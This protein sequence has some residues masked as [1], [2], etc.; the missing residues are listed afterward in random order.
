MGWISIMGEGSAGRRA[1]RRGAAGGGYAFS[2]SAAK[3]I[4]QRP[5]APQARMTS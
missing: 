3:R 4:F 1:A 5:A 2:L